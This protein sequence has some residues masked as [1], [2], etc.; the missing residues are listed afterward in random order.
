MTQ[1]RQISRPRIPEAPEEYSRDFLNQ[2]IRS[3][4]LFMDEQ[5]E[6]GP[7]RFSELSIANVR[8]DGAG[9]RPGYIYQESGALKIVMP[10]DILAPALTVS[11]KLESVTAA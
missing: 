6:L 1:G 4:Q 10:D 3:L 11:T 7:A 5:S 8:N 2:L 9:E